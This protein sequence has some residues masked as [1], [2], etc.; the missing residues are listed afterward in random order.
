M[1]KLF[2]LILAVTMLAAVLCACGPN[3]PAVT[4]T[5]GTGTEGTGTQGGSDPATTTGQGG[6]TSSDPSVKT[7]KFD[8]SNIVLSFAAL[9]DV[10]CQNG[11]AM[12]TNKFYSALNQ[13]K[14][15]AVKSGDKDGIDAVKIAGDLTQTG[16]VSEAQSVRDTYKKVFDETK[17]AL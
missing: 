15:Y 12:P 13:L 11:Y 6:T 1:K 7:D 14:D 17:I 2:A 8:A 16:Q 5:G 9:S 10:H 3:T 4:T